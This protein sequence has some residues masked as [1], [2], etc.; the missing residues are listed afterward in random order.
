VKKGRAM[1]GKTWRETNCHAPGSLK[2]EGIQV[3]ATASL[4]AEGAETGILIEA[5][6]ERNLHPF[7]PMPRR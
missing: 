2:E 5:V 6:Y 1:G 3:A 4:F 7:D